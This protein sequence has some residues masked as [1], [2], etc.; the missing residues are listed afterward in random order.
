[1]AW[2]IPF[3]ACPHCQLQ[4]QLAEL[5]SLRSSLSLLMEQFEALSKRLS[6]S[7]EAKIAA[8][9]TASTNLPRMVPRNF[10]DSK[11]V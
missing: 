9:L 3:S 4:A 10:N 8:A 11:K 5:L 6:S 2:R 7:L 1:M